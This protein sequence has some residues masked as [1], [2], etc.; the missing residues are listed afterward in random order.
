MSYGYEPPRQ[1][2]GGSWREIFLITRMVFG[3]LAPF[4][5]AMVGVIVLIVLEIVLVGI[6]WLLGVVPLLP[7]AAVVFWLLR[8][9]R[10]QAERDAAAVHRD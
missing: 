3:M 4:I 5:G 9:E 6:H 10:R 1:D 8:R 2:Q 7:I